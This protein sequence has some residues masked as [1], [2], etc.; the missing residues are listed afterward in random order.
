[1]WHT[2]YWVNV[3]HKRY[4]FTHLNVLTVATLPWEISQVHNDT[5]QL[6]TL[7]LL[8]H[9]L[10]HNKFNCTTKQVQVQLL[11]QMFEMSAFFLRVGP[12]S[13]LPFVDSIINDT[14]W[15]SV[16]CVS[17]MLLQ[18]GHITSNGKN[19]W[20]HLLH[21]YNV[22][23]ITA[24]NLVPKLTKIRLVH[25]DKDGALFFVHTRVMLPWQTFWATSNV[26]QG[27]VATVCSWGGQI[28]NGYVAD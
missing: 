6:K 21:Q 19:G 4:L 22:A 10:N 12:K 26:S 1:M 14:L 11:Q 9:S 27:S 8:L 7:G 28:N 3:Q 18:I 15:Q 17:Q 2:V 25:P 13:L 23:I 16:P 20:Q 5:C 24:I